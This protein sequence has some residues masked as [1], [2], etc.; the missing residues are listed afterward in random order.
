MGKSALLANW[1]SRYQHHHPEAIVISH[2]IGC[3]PESSNYGGL[4]R[5]VMKELMSK[6]NDDVAAVPSDAKSAIGTY[7]SII[8]FILYCMFFA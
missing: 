5:R 7:P 2:F 3:S 6:L 4:I 1:A 8:S